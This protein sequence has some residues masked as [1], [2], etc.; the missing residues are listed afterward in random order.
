MQTVKKNTEKSFD[1]YFKED[2]RL[3]IRQLAKLN[4]IREKILKDPDED[5]K[6]VIV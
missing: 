2:T 4:N 5:K 3:I 1:D 6:L